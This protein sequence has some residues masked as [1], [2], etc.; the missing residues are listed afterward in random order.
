MMFVSGDSLVSL[1]PIGQQQRPNN[2]PCWPDAGTLRT[3]E[4]RGRKRV[5]E[6]E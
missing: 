2:D 6:E 5:K 1:H 3:R 4:E